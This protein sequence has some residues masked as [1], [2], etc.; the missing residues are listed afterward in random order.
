M[1]EPVQRV[2]RAVTQYFDAVFS[3]HIVIFVIVI[4]ALLIIF[5]VV[6]FLIIFLL[7]LF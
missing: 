5:V 2:S 6:F 7:S 1:Q 3:S 4:T